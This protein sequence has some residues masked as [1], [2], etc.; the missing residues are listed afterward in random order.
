MGE[1]TAQIAVA[2][3]T[4]VPLHGLADD[5][6]LPFPLFLC[7]GD[8]A[9]VL[10]RKAGDSV[11]AAHLGRLR[12]EGVDRLF[13]RGDDLPAY[14]A[15]IESA[16]QDV[17]LDKA[18]PL[19][20]RA[21]VLHGVARQVVNELFSSPIERVG[22]RRAQRVITA[23][24]ALLL[25]ETKAFAAVRAALD[26]Q[27]ELAAHGLRTSMLAMGLARA[28]LSADAAT[29]GE[30]GLA[31]LLHDVGRIGADLGDSDVGHAARGAAMLQKHGL[32]V[33]VVAAVRDHHERVDGSGK[34]NGLR[35]AAAS[36]L[37]LLVGLADVF[38]DLYTHRPAGA[39]LFDVLRVLA[40]TGRERF[41]ERCAQ[42]LV[43]LFRR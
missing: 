29:V 42:A 12:A 24:G 1:D 7:T 9:H 32:S 39:T 15:R 3:W 36:E 13:V 11:D 20:D 34:P 19:A 18:V 25:R 37:G 5:R 4:A 17:L 35:A 31:G 30:A 22:L 38:D 2:A 28:V 43:Q 27:P 10:Y 41:D 6:P 14:Y 26:S 40:T 23:T 33:T 16:L 21:D 8:D